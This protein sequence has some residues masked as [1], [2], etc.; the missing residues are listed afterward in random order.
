MNSRK[1]KRGICGKGK[2]GKDEMTIQKTEL[3]GL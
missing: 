3:H 1:E 2:R